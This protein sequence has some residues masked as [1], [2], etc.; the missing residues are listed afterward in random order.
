[1]FDENRSSLFYMLALVARKRGRRAAAKD[2]FRM[3][4]NTDPLNYWPSILARRELGKLTPEMR[5]FLGDRHR[6]GA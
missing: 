1:L 4:V 5:R 2:L 3:A 6:P